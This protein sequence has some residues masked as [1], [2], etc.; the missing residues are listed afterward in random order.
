MKRLIVAAVLFSP[1]AALFAQEKKGHKVP[2]HI[3]GSV[4][5]QEQPAK[6]YLRYRI[7]GK[8]IT[9]SAVTTD[10]KFS[11]DGKVP[12]PQIAQLVTAAPGKKEATSLFLGKGTTKVAI[13]D[14]FLK[15]T[16]EGTKEQDAFNQLNAL[17]KPFSKE[18]DD[19]IRDYRKAAEAKD[20]AA[21][22]KAET[23]MDEV[24]AS[25]TAV[26]RKY[27]TDNPS[28]PIGMYLL[29]QVAGYELNATD[30]EPIFKS[31]PKK[32]RRY[33]SGKQFAER[34]EIAKKLTV[35]NPAIEFSQNDASG[36]PVSLSSFRGKY[37]LVDFWA[38]WCGPC[39]AENPN[40]VKAYN[41]YKDKGFTI[42][43]VSFDEKKEKWEQAIQQDGLA[44]THVS[45]LKGWSNEVGK[46]Y[47]IRAIPQNVLLDPQGKIVAK[48]LRAEALDAKLAELLK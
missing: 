35:G 24:D 29:N 5:R 9:D 44:W 1:A 12:E 16:A 3:E 15:G 2:F 7:D 25:R 22:K 45:D 18:M 42:L 17:T 32:I 48:N 10:G 43:G 46:L 41:K 19:L 6:F 33:P 8:T 39:R 23:R 36:K 34:L 14:V 40:V 38:S 13:T 28:T 11:F 20:E 47:G 30:I 4:A 26:I 21:Q 27:L 37:V 31:L